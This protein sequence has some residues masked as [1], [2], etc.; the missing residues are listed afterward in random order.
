MAP[1]S[2]YP[3]LN[4]RHKNRKKWIRTILQVAIL[5]VVAWLFINHV[6]DL[7]KYKE[8]NK[9][10]WTNTEG[11]V[12]LSYF[13]VSRSGTPQLI[14]RDLLR[15]HLE[16]LA[17]QGFVTVS[18]QDL[19]DFYQRGQPLPD[20]ALFLAF[21]DGRNDSVLFAQPILEDLNFKAT[22]LSYA[23]KI[24][25]MEGKF[26]QP[27]DMLRMRENGYW[28]LGSNGYR[29]TYI[30]IV[31]KEGQFLGIRDEN[32]F[33]DKEK[34]LYYTHYLMDFIRDK[35]GIP[36]EVRAEMEERIDWDYSQMEKLYTEHLGFV[37]A[38]YM[39]MHANTLYNGMNPLVEEANDRNIRSIFQMHFNREGSAYNSSDGHLYDLTRLQAAPYWYTNHLLMKLKEDTDWEIDWF[40]GDEQRAADWHLL[41][42]ATEFT[43]NAIILTSPPGEEGITRLKTQSV[44]Q[45]ISLTVTLAGN[46]IGQQTI[47]LCYNW[48]QASYLAVSVK[49]NRL[50]IEQKPPGQAVERLVAQELSEIEWGGEDR[51]L[52]EDGTY[53][54]KSMRRESSDVPYPL[55]IQQERE[56]TV[57]LHD[58]RLTVN[59]D[60]VRIAKDL[61]VDDT[62][63]QGSIALG[64]A[65]SDVNEIDHIYDGVFIDLEV[66][67]LDGEKSVP[68][69]SHTFRGWQGVVSRLKGAYDDLMEWAIRM[70]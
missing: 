54:A 53:R 63:G 28:E 47:Y 70:F 34:A 49:D 59:V 2:K 41:R 15:K 5:A 39:I 9:A 37:P 43:E 55:N 18:Q 45:D 61:E 24:G 69:Y 19:I 58:Q 68:I 27:K 33:P 14:A 29:L 23:N 12:A 25:N 52:Q 48:E 40:T 30:N 16:T 66:S 62:I 46:V 57:T 64:A 36:Q 11:F 44:P 17:D 8:P 65:Y 20:K 1:N 35:H 67:T 51:T 32:Q 4:W 60:G 42:G 21:E 56:L 31:D 22:L 38:V 13:G 50:I 7:H 3:Q 10:Q 26:L 6:F